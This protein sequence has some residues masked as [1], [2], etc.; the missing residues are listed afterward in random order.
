MTKTIRW[1]IGITAVYV[2]LFAVTAVYEGSISLILP[3]VLAF[4]LFVFALLG[5]LFVAV[6][7]VVFL[8]REALGGSNKRSQGA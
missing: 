8:I 7:Y 5:C 1:V 3:S 6:L 2:A 4:A